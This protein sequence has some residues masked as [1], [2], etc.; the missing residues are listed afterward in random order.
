MKF[1]MTNHIAFETA[2]RKGAEEFYE[3]VLGMRVA[4]RDSGFTQ[5][6]NDKVSFYVA[7]KDKCP[8][9]ML[10]FL[11]EDQNAAVTHLTKNGCEV[12]Q[13]FGQDCFV[14][15]PYGLVFNVS[16]KS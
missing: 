15:D 14:K 10:D 4:K 7:E 9:L 16:K 2:D 5:F 1:E 3:K 8:G 11:V 12:V 13:R 6:S